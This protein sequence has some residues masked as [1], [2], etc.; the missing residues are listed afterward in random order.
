MMKE[1]LFFTIMLTVK[2]NTV[3]IAGV[4][5]TALREGSWASSHVELA[6]QLMTAGVVIQTGRKTASVL[7][8]AALVLA[9]MPLV[10]VMV[11]SML[12]LTLVMMILLTPDPVLFAT[13]S[14]RTSLSGLCSSET[15]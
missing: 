14:S 10:V 13:L 7:Q 5:E 9:E 6:I 3:D 11:A 8:T 2:R 4:S 12:S 1:L 15:W